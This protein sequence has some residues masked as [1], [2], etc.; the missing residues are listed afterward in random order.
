MKKV[1]ILILVITSLSANAQKAKIY[2]IRSTGFQ[3]SATKFNCFVD[4]KI[5]CKINNKKY[6]V[7]EVEPGQHQVDVQ[8]GGKEYKGDDE[9]LI[10]ETEAGKSYFIEMTLKSG[11]MKNNLLCQE[12]TER[13]AKA[14]MKDL[15]EDDCF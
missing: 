1:L 7:H 8:I 15:E 14:A 9:P 11:F 2:F 12:I 6:S 4:K 10:I 3:G 5:C 13:S